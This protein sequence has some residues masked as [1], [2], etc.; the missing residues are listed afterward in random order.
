MLNADDPRANFP[1]QDVL[2][3]EPDSQSQLQDPSSMGPQPVSDEMFYM[4]QQS[5]EEAKFE[6][7]SELAE[8]L[9]AK[10]IELQSVDPTTSACLRACAI[11]IQG[12]LSQVVPIG[13]NQEYNATAQ[14]QSMP[15]PGMGQPGM[16]QSG[17]SQPGMGQP[18]MEQ[19]SAPD[20]NQTPQPGSQQRPPSKG[21]EKEKQPP[22]PRE[23]KASLEDEIYHSTIE[24]LDTVNYFELNSGVPQEK[25]AE[26]LNEVVEIIKAGM[27]EYANHYSVDFGD[28]NTWDL[29]TDLI[30]DKTFF[31]L[32][33]ARIINF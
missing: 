12:A 1:T 27:D 4:I 22:P 21:K 18:E 13:Q 23:K 26:D 6:L 24:Y 17:S 32:G 30:K 20:P 5:K 19:A 29:V 31:E 15:Q 2:G 28:P 16:D 33:K 14:S 10:A 11:A 8:A 3:Q 7:K 25:L 9:N